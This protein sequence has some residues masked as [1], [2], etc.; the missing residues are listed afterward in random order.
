MTGTSS[1]YGSY[2]V[3]ASATVINSASTIT[4]Y[5]TLTATAN[6]DS[7]SGV[8]QKDKNIAIGVGI[9]LGIPVIVTILIILLF[10]YRRKQLNSVRNY[11]DS[12]GRD[13][14]IVI[15]EGNPIK[16]SLR[17]LFFGFPTIKNVP[18]RGDFDD[19][20]DDIINEPKPNIG[21]GSN[22][23]N[24]QENYGTGF[25]VNRPKP[26]HL[27]N[28]DDNDTRDNDDDSDSGSVV[29]GDYTSD[30]QSPTL[31]KSMS[32]NE[33]SGTELLDNHVIPDTDDTDDINTD[34]YVLAPDSTSPSGSN[35]GTFPRLDQI[36]I[37]NFA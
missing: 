16:K 20:N 18:D 14:G 26:L 3:V 11:V 24:D 7:V 33:N 21:Y 4:L 2:I 13:A 23:N 34:D 31:P 35:G 1:N 37:F 32:T 28:S 6:A 27:V 29:R 9:G 5:Q 10:L 19:D 25:V 8:S 12:N 15:E 30:T 17:R 22:Y 36:I